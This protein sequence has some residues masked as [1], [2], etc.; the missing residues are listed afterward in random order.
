MIR[1]E[2]PIILDNLVSCGN[3]QKCTYWVILGNIL[4][5]DKI[6]FWKIIASTVEREALPKGIYTQRNTIASP[7]MPPEVALLLP[8]QHCGPNRL[9]LSKIPT[10]CAVGDFFAN[11]VLNIHKLIQVLKSNNITWVTNLP[12]LSQHDTEFRHNLAEVGIGYEMEINALSQI[13]RAG[14]KIIAAAGTPADADLAKDLDLDAL[15][16]IPPVDAF[17]TGFPSTF[18]RA[19]QIK[20][21]RNT[22]ISSEIA[23]LG[24]VTQAENALVSTWPKGLDGAVMRPQPLT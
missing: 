15:L 17:E 24:L 4:Q 20:I 22:G 16:V 21:I 13:K 19:A 12:S 11:P 9:E 2:L 3:L 14:I 23:L 6:L 1:V 7:R 10:N 18:K 5:N 8:G